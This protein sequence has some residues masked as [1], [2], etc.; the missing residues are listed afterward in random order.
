M[1]RITL[2]SYDDDPPLGGQGGQVRGMRTALSERGHHVATLSG[3]GVNARPYPR[4]TGRAPFDFSLHL[5]RHPELIRTTV[6]DVVH[7]SGGPGGVLLVRDV[8]APVVYTA[9]HT[10]RM[11]HGR[12]SLRRLL[13]PLEGRAY[14]RAAMVLAISESTAAAV[15]ALGVDSRRVAILPPGVDVP[16]HSTPSRSAPR[17]LFAGR[18]EPEKGVLDAVA[19]MRAVIARRP[20]TT[21]LVV[22]RGSLAAQ[23]HDSAAGEPAIEVAGHVDEA[24]LAAEYAR[25]SVVLMPSQYEGLGLVALQAQAHGAVAVGYDV[26]GLR[27]AIAHRLLV[28]PGD[29]SALAALCVDLLDAPGRREELAI[30]AIQQVRAEHSWEV[31]ARH[32]D[33]VYAAVTTSG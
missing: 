17:L 6:P 30:Q 13:S 4:V 32:L 29:V 18:W 16:A 22:G 23:V 31:M 8:G 5:N 12:G 9:N 15:R 28:A 27:D 26:E 14:R 21:A 25:A 19:A 33:Q 20:G 24:R 3:R 11:A 2:V 7:A 10:Y 1:S